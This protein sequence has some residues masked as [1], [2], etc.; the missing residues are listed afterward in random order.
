MKK[1]LGS[2][3]FTLVELMV[4]VAIIGILSAV[5]VPN[6]KTYQAKAKQ[7]EA[8]VAL[9]EVYTLEQGSLADVNTYVTCLGALGFDQPATGFYIVGYN[10][11]TS[12]A[13]N[14]VNGTDCANAVAATT[15]GAVAAKT[16]GQIQP[17][18]LK[19]TGPT[20]PTIAN[21][22]LGPA[23][24]TAAAAGSIST[25]TLVDTWTLNEGKVLTNTTTGF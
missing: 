14:K 21:G 18:L 19:K 17:L 23:V 4:V 15:A 7:S 12:T 16:D 5:A 9:A 3:G 11:T 22:S 6:F 8:K 24:F 2:T 25:L 13:T 1:I 10:S 20:T